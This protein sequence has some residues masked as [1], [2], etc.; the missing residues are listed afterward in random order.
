MAIKDHYL[1]TN[2]DLMKLVI[3][4][5][6]EQFLAVTVGM[7]DTMMISSVSEAAVS[8]VSLVDS[9]SVLL[10]N[11][12]AALATGGAVVCGQ[13]IG[14]KQVDQSQVAAKQLVLFVTMISVLVMLVLFLGQGFI[15]NVVFGHIDA[16]VYRYAQTYLWIT[17]L[18]IPFI[19]IYNCGAAIF[20]AIRDSK[21][22]MLV[23][24]LMNVINV[25]GNAILIFGFRF[26]VEGVAIPT[27]VSRVVGAFII[28]ALLY[29][30]RL[31][32]HFDRSFSVRLNWEMIGK[33][34][35]IGIPSGVENSM[36]QLG[37]IA[38]LSLVAYFGTT[39]IAANAVANSLALFQVLPGMAIG[40]ALV[41]VT[42]QCV[43]AK[44]FEQVRYYT[45]KLMG[46]AYGSHLVLDVTV[47]VLLPYILQ[48]YQLTPETA[49]VTTEIIM[50]HTLTAI[51]I[52]PL[53]FTLPN[54]LRAAND[55]AYTMGVSVFSMWMFRI[56]CGYV[57]A[58]WFNCGLHGVWYA[59]YID[60][61]VRMIFFVWRYF[62]GKWEKIWI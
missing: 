61:I 8:A 44:D 11:I 3:P 51:T 50:L 24:V 6:I 52:W 22:S 39:A 13:Y 35:R 27:L 60:W 20:R 10:I 38:L 45:K 15:L 57:L 55:A 32:V 25:A 59:M 42:S 5:I 43:G 54:M 56:V 23:S 30:P 14:K 17:G 29:N 46:Y 4:L 58:V 40:L 12:F 28:M 7:V 62:S 47:M 34:L 9:I 49:K 21:T 33:I 16:D 26:G 53:A 19:A 41:T 18:S 48:V 37:K 2:K 31:P 36:F 1:F